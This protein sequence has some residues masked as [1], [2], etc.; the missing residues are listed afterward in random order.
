[1]E[2]VSVRRAR[3]IWLVD[4]RDLNPRGIDIRPV[5]EA[6]KDRYRFRG[7]P[8]TAE[9]VNEQSPKGIAFSDGSLSTAD[10]AYSIDTA[11]IY[12]DGL[13]VD[14]GLSTD[15]SEEFL[16]DLLSF[17]SSNFALKYRSEMIHKKIYASELIVRTEKNLHTVLD[18][19]SAIAER[20]SRIVGTPFEP[21]GIEFSVDHKISP[22]PAP[23]TFQREVNKSFD[24]H[25]YYSSAPLKTN[26]HEELLSLLESVL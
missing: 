6:V 25:R 3:A 21:S 13:V 16:A 15:L 24:Q 11:T 12:G 22:R 7:F 5:L 2:L 14:S 18:K 20:L 9:E 23:F 4:A 8:K 26:E 19:L 17:V 1:M 10:G